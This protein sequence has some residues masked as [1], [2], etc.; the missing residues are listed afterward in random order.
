MVKHFDILVMINANCSQP[1]WVASTNHLRC[2]RKI[3]NPCLS[4][5]VTVIARA[6]WRKNMHGPIKSFWHKCTNARWCTKWQ[7]VYGHLLQG[8]AG[9][10]QERK[11]LL[12][13]VVDFDLAAITPISMSCK[14]LIFITLTLSLP[15]RHT[16]TRT[17]MHAQTHAWCLYL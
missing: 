2:L 3:A 4:F 6:K 11:N 14:T 12:L 15:H 13:T 10:K 1:A 16:H 9:V 17:H 7:M 8:V 5:S